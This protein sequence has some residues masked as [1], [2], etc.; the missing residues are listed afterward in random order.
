MIWVVIIS[1]RLIVGVRVSFAVGF[2]A[3]FIALL[4]GIP[5]GAVAGYY[6]RH[7]PVIHLGK[8]RWKLPADGF[9]MGR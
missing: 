3:V 8:R 5:V 2:V 6:Q 9:I 7:P 4:I 1:S